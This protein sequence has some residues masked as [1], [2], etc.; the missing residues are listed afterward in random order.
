MSLNAM[1]SPATRE[2]EPL[3][4]FVRWLTVAKADREVRRPAAGRCMLVRPRRLFV[5]LPLVVAVSLEV[6]RS[7]FYGTGTAAV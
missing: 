7:G 6:A 4:R 3:V 5:V 1:A 2:P